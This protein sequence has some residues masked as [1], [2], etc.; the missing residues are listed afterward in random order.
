MQ[1]RRASGSRRA[2]RRRAPPPTRW[3]GRSGRRRRPGRGSR[4]PAA[5]AGLLSWTRSA[6][7]LARRSRRGRRPASA[8]S[9]SSRGSPV[10][11]QAG[12]ESGR[13]R[14]SA[15]L[16]RLQVARAAARARRG[17]SATPVRGEGAG[18][19]ERVGPDAADRVGGHQQAPRCRGRGGGGG[20]TAACAERRRGRCRGASPRARSTPVRQGRRVGKA[21]GGADGA[22]VGD[23]VALVAG[24]PVARTRS[25][26][27]GRPASRCGRG[28]G[29]G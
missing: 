12:V 1:A 14:G 26:P 15:G 2:A 11:R 29:A 17:W 13:G 10:E 21:E 5:R 3:R 9:A 7:R 8:I 16:G 6:L 28:A 4:A 27:G 23:V 20:R 19:V 25:R 24:A 18:E 22:G